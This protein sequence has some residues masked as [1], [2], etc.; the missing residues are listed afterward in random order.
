LVSD[1]RGAIWLAS[2]TRAQNGN[3]MLV[4]RRLRPTDTDMQIVLAAEGYDNAFL[5]L[6]DTG[7]A[8]MRCNV[9]VMRFE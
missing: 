6:D 8:T 1:D 5:A 2:D 4:V 9:G 3:P 7:R